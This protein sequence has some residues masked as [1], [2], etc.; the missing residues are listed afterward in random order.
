MCSGI[1][2]AT[3]GARCA[4]CQRFIDALDARHA[5]WKEDAIAA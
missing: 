4:R 1:L 5:A 3:D 2:A